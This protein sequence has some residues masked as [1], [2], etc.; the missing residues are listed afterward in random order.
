MTQSGAYGSEN[1]GASNRN[2]GEIPWGRNPKVSFAMVI[3]EG[4]VGPNLMAKAGGDGQTVNIPSLWR[5]A[6]GGRSAVLQAN[7]W[8]FVHYMRKLLQVNPGSNIPSIM[9]WRG[10]GHAKL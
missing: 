10:F 5:H 9:A 7:Y 4:L 2:Q 8:I 3:S 6:M 1:A